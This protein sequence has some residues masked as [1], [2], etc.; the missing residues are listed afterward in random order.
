[1]KITKKK[2]KCPCCKA[3]GFIF[4]KPILRDE[5]KHWQDR[6]DDPET[7]DAMDGILP[8]GSNWISACTHKTGKKITMKQEWGEYECN[9]DCD[10]L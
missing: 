3:E 2:S 5:Y 6:S 1:M 7:N 9:C 8:E 10:N 4:S